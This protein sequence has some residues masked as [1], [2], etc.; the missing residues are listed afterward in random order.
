MIY[1]TSKFYRD[2]DKLEKL[3]K[4]FYEHFISGDHENSIYLFELTKSWVQGQYGKRKVKLTSDNKNPKRACFLE[5]THQSIDP[6]RAWYIYQ[7]ESD[8]QHKFVW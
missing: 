3:T 5:V 4:E 1:G 2:N 6:P 7:L 8:Y